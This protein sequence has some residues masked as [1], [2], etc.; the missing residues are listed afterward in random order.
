M[1]PGAST[2]PCLYFTERFISASSALNAATLDASMTVTPVS[3]LSNARNGERGWT[4]L[5]DQRLARQE[6]R[7]AAPGSEAR[8]R[9]EG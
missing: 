6:A 9:G 4:N 1:T 5:E 2:R 7:H 8:A 3:M